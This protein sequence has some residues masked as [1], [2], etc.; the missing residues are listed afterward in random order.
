MKRDFDLQI[1][2]KVLDGIAQGIAFQVGLLIVL[3]VHEVVVVAVVVEEVH[4]DF[5]DDDALDRIRGAEALHEHG[6]GADIAQL[7]LDEGAQVARG[8]VLHGEDEV[9]VV[10]VL[11][12][13]AWAHLGGG[14][15]HRIKLLAEMS[16]E[17]AAGT[18]GGRG[19]W[20]PKGP[21]GCKLRQF[22]FYRR[23]LI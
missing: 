5:V 12:D 19:W 21:P 1:R 16:A 7:G 3:G 17:C 15:R 8:T 10:V 20:S 13:H 11:D 22:R 14:N 18:R 4:R 2:N 23:G 9:E 6:A